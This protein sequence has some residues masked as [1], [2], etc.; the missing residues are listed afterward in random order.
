MS[1]LCMALG[2]GLLGYWLMRPT[3][4]PDERVVFSWGGGLPLPVDVDHDGIDDL[5]GS[6]AGKLFLLD[7]KTWK[8]RWE[9]PSDGFV[10]RAGDGKLAVASGW[11]LVLRSLETG[12]E[13]SRAKKSDRIVGLCYE[14]GVLWTRAYDEVVSGTRDN[15][16]PV[17]SPGK[18][19]PCRP[20]PRTNHCGSAAG[21]CLPYQDYELVDGSDRVHLGFKRPGTPIAT[22][23]GSGADGKERFRQVVEA[24][25]YGVAG[26]ELT[27][28]RLYV[29]HSGQVDAFDARTGTP[30]WSTLTGTSGSYEL[31]VHHGRVYTSGTGHRNHPRLLIF[32]AQTGRKLAQLG[33]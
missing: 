33:G 28:G 19:L 4:A 17:A 23:I 7:G 27:D 25:G 6:A 32:D 22:A 18:E 24:H 15:G 31:L 12:A 9:V 16:D 30:L 29:L 14:G 21:G 2:G 11:E 8:Q 26:A 1:A 3:V 20:T 5:V 13:L 10:S